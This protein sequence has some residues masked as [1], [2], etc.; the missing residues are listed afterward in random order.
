VVSTGSTDGQSVVEEVALATVSK[1]GDG[2]RGV[3]PVVSTGSTDGQSVVEEV[4]LATVSKP[5]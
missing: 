3:S 4:A 5:R 2:A 1:P